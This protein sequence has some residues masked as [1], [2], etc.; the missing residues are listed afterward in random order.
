M[1]ERSDTSNPQSLRG[2]SPY[3]P[4]GPEAKSQNLKFTTTVYFVFYSL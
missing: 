1:I 4:Y 3:G 2:V